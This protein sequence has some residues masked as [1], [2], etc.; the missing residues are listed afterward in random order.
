LSRFSLPFNS[1]IKPKLYIISDIWGDENLKWLNLYSVLLG[2]KYELNFI[3]SL[4]L[5]EISRIN[6]SNQDIHRQFEGGGIEE[7]VNNL[8]RLIKERVHILAFSVGGTIAWKFALEYNL[9]ERLICVSS[10]RL[11]YEKSNPR[12]DLKLIYGDQD[13]FMPKEEWFENQ[14]II[15]QVLPNLNHE[16]YKEKLCADLICAQ[17]ML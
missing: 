13:E 2:I 6:S 12:C 10:T 5:A 17:L 16:C 7:A 1:R 11:R 8:S 14:N 3:N 9:V 4:E 15:P